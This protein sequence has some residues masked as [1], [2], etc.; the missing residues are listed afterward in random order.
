MRIASIDLQPSATTSLG[1]SANFPAVWLGHVVNFSIQVVFTGTPVG[2]FKLQ[3]SDDQGQPD[4]G[5]GT[6]G[7]ATG[8]TNWT[9]IADSSQSISAAGD[10]TWNYANAGFRFVRVVYT[11]TSGTGTVTSARCSIKGV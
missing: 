5:T 2:V 4:G 3:A 7:L 11:R 1:A 10:M 6:A 8:V 9:D